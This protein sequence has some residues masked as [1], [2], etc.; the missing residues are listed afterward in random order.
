MTQQEH[1]NYWRSSSDEDWLIAKEIAQKNSRKHFALFVAHLSLEKLLKALFVK[2]FNAVPPYKHD[3]YLLA[4]KCGIA[5]SDTDIND[6]K[7]VNE[8][9]IQARYPEYKNDFYKKCTT[10]FVVSEL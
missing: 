7:I 2:R 9:N 1:I 8:F 3:L 5:L 4:E 10:E 6:L